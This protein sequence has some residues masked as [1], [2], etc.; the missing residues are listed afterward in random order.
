MTKLLFKILLL[1]I[2]STAA[3]TKD[4]SLQAQTFEGVKYDSM[5]VT[6]NWQWVKLPNGVVTIELNAD[7]C[8]AV[9]VAFTT[10]GARTKQRKDS[11]NIHAKIK[12]G[13]TRWFN[14]RDN[15]SVGFKGSGKIYYWIYKGTGNPTHFNNPVGATWDSLV[16]AVYTKVQTDSRYL[17]KDS[18]NIIYNR[19]TVS[20]VPTKVFVANNYQPIGNYYN[21][22]NLDTSQTGRLN[23]PETVTGAW[24][25]NRR[26][27]ILDSVLIAGFLFYK[28]NNAG[29]SYSGSY[30]VRDTIF[31]ANINLG[32]GSITSNN[33]NLQAGFFTVVASGGFQWSVRGQLTT[34]SDGNFLFQNWSGS[35]M[36]SILGGGTT[37]SFPALTRSGAGWL[38]QLADL[39]G[40][41]TVQSLYFRSGTGS[42][43]GSVTAPVGTEYVRTDGTAGTLKY[44]K[45]TG[46]GNTGWVAKW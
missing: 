28:K 18:L 35:G 12:R 37:S 22:T 27:S 7:S 44:L 16:N 41:T 40:Y 33:N 19:D 9:N 5:T 10:Y 15:D 36:G 24:T 29:I 42:P 45:E 30:T 46:S 39:T 11:V 6:S 23:Q 13:Q 43:E 2:L 21:T 38:A 34:P 3:F 8:S 25:F 31:A 20:K 4:G 32:G 17:F 26:T 1:V 14:D